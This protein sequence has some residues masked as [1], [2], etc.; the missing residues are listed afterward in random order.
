MRISAVGLLRAE[1]ML[2]KAQLVSRITELLAE[3]GLSQ[4]TAATLLGVPQPK[5]SKMLRGQFR[6]FSEQKLLGCLMQL[7]Q[8]V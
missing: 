3:K 1:S 5:L 8:G 2:V 7:R 6:G 4:I